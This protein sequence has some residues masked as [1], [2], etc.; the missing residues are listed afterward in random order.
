M[1]S[2]SRQGDR[3]R[4]LVNSSNV[5]LETE[6][7]TPG[8]SSSPHGVCSQAF[9]HTS[10]LTTRYGKP[11]TGYRALWEVR[12]MW[13]E[14]CKMRSQPDALVWKG[15]KIPNQPSCIICTQ[16]EIPRKEVSIVPARAQAPAVFLLLRPC[17]TTGAHS[18]PATWLEHSLRWARSSQRGKTFPKL[19]WARTGFWAYTS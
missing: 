13:T 12:E 14:T 16:Q 9:R 17:V 6:F 7:I 11:V 18:V 2:W 8:E 10:H 15:E 3:G 4:S 19:L 5:G 1:L